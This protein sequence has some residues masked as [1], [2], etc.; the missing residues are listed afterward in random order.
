MLKPTE[1]MGEY[2][3][4]NFRYDPDTGYLWWTK[5]CESKNGRRQL[6]KPVGHVYNTHKYV[7]INLGLTNGQVSCG[8]HRIA[9]FLH[10]GS[11]PKDVLDHINGIKNDNKIA[12]LREVTSQQNSA[13]AKKKSNCSSQYKGVSFN[14]GR[15]KWEARVCISYKDKRIGYYTSEEEA[16]RAYDKA[17]RE[18]FGDYAC[19]NFPDEHEQGAT[20]GPDV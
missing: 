15:K 5:P 17:A 2:I 12:N 3:K 20:H 19:L 16:A 10:Y 4:E 6:D 11:W 14:K 9:W 7:R 8:A 18:K 1:E 13:N